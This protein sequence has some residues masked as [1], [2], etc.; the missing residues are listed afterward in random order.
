[1]GTGIFFLPAAGALVAGAASLVSWGIMSLFAIYIS[2]CFAELCSMFPSAGG[3]YEFC[4]QA[5]GRVPSFL[6]GWLTLI[7]GNI[8]I[9]ML[10]IG[11]ISYLLPKN[12]P[13]LEIVIMIISA[14]FLILFNAIAYRGMKTSAIMLVTFSFVTLGTLFALTVPSFFSFSVGNF[15]PFFHYKYPL[16]FLAIFFIAETFFGWESPTFLAGET[17]DGKRVVPRAIFHGTILICIIAFVFVFFTMGTLGW[18]ALGN[19]ANPLSD[20]AGAHFGDFGMSVFRVL[21]YLA[22]IGSVADWVVSAPRLILSMSKDKLFLPQF[23]KIHKKFQTPG[24]AI[25][26]QCVISIIFV[27]L[28]LGSY[29]TL[30][31][32]LVPLLLIMYSLVMLSVVILRFKKP[33][34]KRYFKAPFGK[35]GPI[36]VVLFFAA[37]LVA[38]LLMTHDAVN[39]LMR[40]LVLILIGVPVYLLLEMYYDPRAIRLTDDVLAYFTLLTERFALPIGV[41]KEIIKLLGNIKG[42]NVLE[43]GCSVGTLTMHLAEEVGPSGGIWATDISKRQI[44]IVQKRAMKRGHNHVNALH[45]IQHSTRVHPNV[46]DIHTIVSVGSL[47]YLQ[48]VNKVLKEMNKKLKKGSKICFVDYDKFFDIIPN[49]DWLS[50][51]EKIKSVFMKSGFKV[52]VIRKQGFAWKYIYIYGVKIKNL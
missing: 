43:F 6:L 41:R 52:S 50:S 40:G 16:I 27:F 4:K 48:D 29:T 35:I 17:K 14:L 47:G 32:L 26:L 8:T 30:L 42:K 23:T 24:R 33:N 19:S 49:V 21:V 45:D 37:L 3:V 15:Q 34:V 51:D 25:I 9:A 2:M 10:I 13:S 11:A 38:W 1:M 46:P 36:I 18:Q 31:H 39:V 7:A 28:G 5:Y 44:S 22:I 12:L 20:L